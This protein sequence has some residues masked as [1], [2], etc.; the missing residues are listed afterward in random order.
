MDLQT[1]KLEL[2]KLI[3]DVQSEQLLTLI[4][5]FLIN[6]EK[7]KN[8]PKFSAEESA[9]ILKINEELPIAIQVSYQELLQKSVKNTLSASEQVELLKITP[10]VEA[11][12]VERLKY[13]YQLS[14]LWNTTVD[15]VMNRLQIK[16]PPVI[17][18]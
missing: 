2:I 16:P 12:N 5:S 13:L 1:K 6:A 17:H 15:D 4:K 11:K 18:A 10:I 14:L 9:L 8:T 3:A 7:K